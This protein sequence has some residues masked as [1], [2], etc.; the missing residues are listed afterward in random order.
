MR[1]V[2]DASLLVS[3]FHYFCGPCVARYD[4][5]VVTESYL[6]AEVPWAPG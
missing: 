3:A 6:Q 5:I 4:A 1:I 2:S